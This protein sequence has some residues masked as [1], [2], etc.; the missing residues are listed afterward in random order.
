MAPNG[1]QKD[2]ASPAKHC[3]VTAILF[4]SSC[5]ITN[6]GVG[7]NDTTSDIC[8]PWDSQDHKCQWDWRKA[9][10]LRAC[11]WFTTYQHYSMLH[12]S[13][14][15]HANSHL[16]LSSSYPAH[17]V[18]FTLGLMHHGR[19][20]QQPCSPWTSLRNLTVT[21]GRVPYSLTVYYEP[22]TSGIGD[23]RDDAPTT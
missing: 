7:G 8:R 22:T 4:A 17:G 23:E 18:N 6:S 10:D 12:R 16:D 11:Q 1:R 21:N 2:R 14:S 20:S 5:P 19:M 9:E 3:L 13:S 15:C